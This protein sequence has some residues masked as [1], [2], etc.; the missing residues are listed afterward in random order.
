MSLDHP[1][2]RWP[3]SS[4]KLSE[5]AAYRIESSAAVESSNFITN[6]GGELVAHSLVRFKFAIAAASTNASL[7]FAL[8]L[9][10]SSGVPAAFQ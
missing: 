4:S 5:L 10:F 7:S 6:G 3:P 1:L 8:F 9:S 2:S